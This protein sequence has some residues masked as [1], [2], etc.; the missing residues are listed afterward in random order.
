VR[1][2]VYAVSVAFVIFC[3]NDGMTQ[4]AVSHQNLPEVWRKPSGRHSED[5]VVFGDN[6]MGITLIKEWYN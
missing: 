2:S 3:E 6:A 1:D 5:F 4:G